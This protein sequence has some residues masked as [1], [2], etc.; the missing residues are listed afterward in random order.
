M[1]YEP[2]TWQDGDIVTANKL[3]KIEQG[4]TNG[5]NMIVRISYETGIL[6]KTWQEIHD[7]LANGTIVTFVRETPVG[8]MMGFLCATLNDSTTYAVF[9]F[10]CMMN[11]LTHFTFIT[12]TPT[13]YPIEG[14]VP[15]SD[16]NDDSGS[17]DSGGGK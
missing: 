11:Q 3:N 16:D 2:T 6:D 13:G 8:A 1:A 4:I 14:D 10:Q 9:G 12:N 7:A 5:G 15:N 17:D